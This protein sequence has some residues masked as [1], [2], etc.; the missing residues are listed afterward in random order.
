[1]GHLVQMVKLAC[2]GALIGLGISDVWQVGYAPFIGL[3]VFYLL[4]VGAMGGARSLGGN[5]R[6]QPPS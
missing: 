2:V 5:E 6:G 3:L 1:M 4:L